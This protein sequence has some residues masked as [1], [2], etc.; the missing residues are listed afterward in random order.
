VLHCRHLSPAVLHCCQ[1]LGYTSRLAAATLAPPSLPLLLLLLQGCTSFPRSLRLS[2]LLTA[3]QSAP[4]A[5]F[6]QQLLQLLLL[7]GSGSQARRGPQSADLEMQLVEVH[8]AVRGEAALPT[9]W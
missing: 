2:C 5:D 4:A 6:D 8:C 9:T 1:A 7:R 3:C